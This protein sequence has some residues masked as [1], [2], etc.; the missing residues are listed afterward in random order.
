MS[1]TSWPTGRGPRTAVVARFG[2]SRAALVE[3]A[4]RTGDPLADAAGR[5][6]APS[7]TRAS[8]T[9]SPRS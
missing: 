6:S 2:E 9:A 7:S 5:L 1:P 4:L 8:G 3:R